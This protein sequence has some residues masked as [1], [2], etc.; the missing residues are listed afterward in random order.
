MTREISMFFP[1]Y[2]EEENIPKLVESADKVLKRVADKYEIIIVLYEGSTDNSQKII[3][4]YQEKY[5]NLR[6]VLQPKGR[7][8]MGIALRMGFKAAK[9][10]LIFYADSDNQFDIEEF[11]RF[12]PYLERYDVIAGYRIKRQDPKTRIIVSNIYNFI[13]RKL[14]RLKERDLDCAFRLVKKRVIDNINLKCKTG[15]STSE[16]LARARKKG[17]KIIEVGVNH[18]PR[19]LGKPIFT[20][21]GLNLPRPKVVKDLIKEMIVLKKD[22]R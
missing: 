3:K 12:L 10:P 6:L 15:V 14:F 20:G 18:Y 19:T 7:K 4:E 16:L 13:M 21:K 8:G 22:L 9:Y 2:D 17:Y 5:S 11:K 1:A